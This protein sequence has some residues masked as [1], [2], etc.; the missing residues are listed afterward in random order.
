MSDKHDTKLND[1]SNA[2]KNICKCAVK[3]QTKEQ[4]LKA[5]EEDRQVI[6]VMTKETVKGKNGESEKSVKRAFSRCRKTVKENNL[7]WKHSNCKNILDYTELY[8]QSTTDLANNSND[9]FKKKGKLIK[10]SKTEYMNKFLQTCLENNILRQRVFEFCEKICQENTQKLIMPLGNLC[11]FKNTSSDD[12]SDKNS[13][14]SSIPSSIQSSQ[15]DQEPE[16]HEEHEEL[17]EH[18]EPKTDE[19]HEEQKEIKANKSIKEQKDED[20]DEDEDEDLEEE[21]EDEEDIH[22]SDNDSNISEREIFEISDT[23]NKKYLC[24]TKTYDLFI[25]TTDEYYGDPYAKLY[26]VKYKAAPFNYNDKFYIA[27]ISFKIKDKL[28]IRCRIGNKIY[29]Y[30]PNELQQYNHI[31]WIKNQNNK[32]YVIFKGSK[33]KIFI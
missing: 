32:E 15:K 26:E 9:F 11:L 17:E 14:P 25:P 27:G 16:E 5:I 2:E 31:G 8:N 7:C 30:E 28:Y 33:E 24:D 29:D 13:I 21:E 3:F 12:K 4:A 23:N 18:E 22:E 1:S 6:L 19:K 20:E 10:S